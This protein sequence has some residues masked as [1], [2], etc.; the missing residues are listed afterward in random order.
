MDAEGREPFVR[1]WDKKAWWPHTEALYALVLSYQLTGEQWCLEWYD[2][3]P[4]GHSLIT[5]FPAENGVSASRVKGV[6][7]TR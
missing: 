3:V 2:K 7:R 5:R 1:N 6:P 4:N